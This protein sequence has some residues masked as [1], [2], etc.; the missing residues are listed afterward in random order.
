[1]I[2]KFTGGVWDGLK[3][4]AA[5]APQLCHL[6]GMMHK[7]R[8]SPDLVETLLESEVTGTSY[9]IAETDDADVVQYRPT[10]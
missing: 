8:E 4:E 9:Q 1:M 2:L 3:I 10:G 6:S 5:T 7:S